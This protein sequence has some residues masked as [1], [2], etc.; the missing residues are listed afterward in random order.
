MERFAVVTRLAT[1]SSLWVCGFDDLAE[2]KTRMVDLSRQTGL[3]HFVHDFAI[4]NVVATSRESSGT[5]GNPPE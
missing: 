5:V 3:R 4:G 1:G 2:A